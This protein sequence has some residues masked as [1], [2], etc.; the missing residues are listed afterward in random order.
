MSSPGPH[1]GEEGKRR[2]RSAQRQH[3]QPSAEE[4]AHGE[5]VAHEGEFAVSGRPTA[6]FVL[7]LE[8]REDQLAGSL[9]PVGSHGRSIAFH[10]WVD[11]LTAID[12]LRMPG[13]SHR[14]VEEPG[15]PS[16]T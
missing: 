9:E 4:Q 5:A 15:P 11:F 14:R 16:T 6:R 1:G 2:S 3:P 10:G 8:L 7:T 13:S 12:Q